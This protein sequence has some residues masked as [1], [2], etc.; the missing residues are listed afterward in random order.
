MSSQIVDVRR[1]REVLDVAPVRTLDY[2]AQT[3]VNAVEY[4]IEQKVVLGCS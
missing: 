3:F 2:Q 4:V 1:T